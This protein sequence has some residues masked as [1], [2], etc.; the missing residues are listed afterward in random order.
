MWAK[1]QR[2]CLKSNLEHTVVQFSLCVSR[3]PVL[4]L[5]DYNQFL[6]CISDL[7]PPLFQRVFL[8]W[9]PSC[10]GV[11]GRGGVTPR[12]F[13]LGTRWKW[14][15]SFTPRPFYP[16][17]NCPCS[18][19]IGDWVGHSRS[20][21]AGEEKNPQPLPG[22]QPPMIHPIAQQYTTELW[23]GY[24]IACHPFR[25]QSYHW[26]TMHVKNRILIKENRICIN[27]I[28]VINKQ[29]HERVILLLLLLL[30]YLL[31]WW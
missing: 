9:A 28:P 4:L 5:G 17:R 3:C 19:W 18:H 7:C 13:Y 10:G 14:V 23:A 8:T 2:T 22:L 1:W 29:F 20:R 15:V 24:S 11:F 6:Q 27:K 26:D 21:R 25:A 12:I 16:Q 31:L 30:L